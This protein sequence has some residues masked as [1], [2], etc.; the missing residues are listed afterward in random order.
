M[1]HVYIPLA[2]MAAGPTAWLL[3]EAGLVSLAALH[4][5][6]RIAIANSYYAAQIFALGRV[7][8]GLQL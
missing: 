2:L 6:A 5:Y 3:R 8:F 1:Q 7:F 4:P